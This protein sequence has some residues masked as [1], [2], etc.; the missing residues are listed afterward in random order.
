LFCTKA[1]QVWPPLA[2]AQDWKAL[3]AQLPQKV[4]SKMRL[5]SMKCASQSQPVPAQLACG[6]PQFEGSGAEPRASEGAELAGQNQMLMPSD[7]H[8][9]A[10]VPPPCALNAVPYE[11]VLLLWKEQP[12]LP[13]TEVSQSVLA[14]CTSDCVPPEMAHPGLV[15][16][17]M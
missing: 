2:A 13:L 9:M 7:V 3:P 1:S 4:V 8:S 17:V 14:G 6:S 12:S 16:S 11:A 10:Y 15:C 5:W